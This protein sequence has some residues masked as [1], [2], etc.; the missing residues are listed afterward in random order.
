LE[1]L[2]LAAAKNS[3]SREGNRMARLGIKQLSLLAVVLICDFTLF[4]PG[5]PASNQPNLEFLGGRWWDGEKFIATTFYSVNGLFAAVRPNHVDAVLNLDGKFVVPPYADAHVHN[6]ADPKDLD[7]DI[8]DDLADGVLYAMEMDPALEL[9]PNVL[10]RVNKPDSVDVIYTQGLVTP[11]WGVMADMYTMLAQM[12]RFGERKTIG[13]VD[14]REVFLIDNES[15]LQ[16]KWPALAAKN[17]DFIKVIVAFSEEEAKRRGNSQYGGKPPEYSAKAGIEP[18]VLEQLVQRAHAAGLRVSAHIETAADFRLALNSGV[19]IIAHLPAAW[20]IGAKTGFTDG[21]LEHWKLTPDDA[22]L[23]TEKGTLVVTTIFKESSD[24]DA[25]KYHEVYEHNLHLLTQAGARLILGTDM[26]GSIS[27]EVHY[28]ASLRVLD[29]R[30]L[31]KTLTETTPK[32]IFPSRKIGELRDGYEASFLA[33]DAN[34]LKDLE[35]IKRISFRVKQ[36]HV[37]HVT[38]NPRDQR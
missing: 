10:G 16:Q 18:A 14:T 25:Q 9:S 19:D 24:P 22:R 38:A 31:L 3:E 7:G 6:L 8:H 5:M 37:I 28:I 32:A 26:R 21:S 11:S 29:N 17:H 34:P 35:S 15:D 4:L 20:Q 36:G 27:D 1:I 12:G 30:A 23:T 2:M 33:L 13:Q